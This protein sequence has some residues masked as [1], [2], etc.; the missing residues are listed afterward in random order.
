MPPEVLQNDGWGIAP[1]SD[2]V[3]YTD[4]N[5]NKVGMLLPHDVGDRSGQAAGVGRV[6]VQFAALLGAQEI[7][8]S[9]WPD[10]AADMGGRDPVLAALHRDL[11]LPNVIRSGENVIF[12]VMA[13]A[14]VLTA[15]H[16]SLADAAQ[17]ED[18]ARMAV[19]ASARR[20]ARNLGKFSDYP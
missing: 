7:L 17:A 19:H 15:S 2:V 6:I 9:L 4:A 8:Q 10:Q 13:R 11:P 14:V 18:G 3:G 12:P 16:F 5:N 1:D 20:T